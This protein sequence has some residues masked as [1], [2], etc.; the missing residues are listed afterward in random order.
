MIESDFHSPVIH[1][2]HICVNHGICYYAQTLQIESLL[3]IPFLFFDLKNIVPPLK[4]V[5]LLPARMYL[6]TRH[7]RRFSTIILI[8]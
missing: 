7:M 4:T 3:L 2:G 6:Y 8:P 1:T 5:H